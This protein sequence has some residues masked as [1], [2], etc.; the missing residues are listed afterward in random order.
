MPD[1]EPSHLPRTQEAVLNVIAAHG[2]IHAYDIKR[3]LRGVLQH[4]S[5][6]A[7]LSALQAKGYLTAEWSLPEAES[8]G[9]GPPRKY[10]EL[11]AAGRQLVPPQTRRGATKLARE[12]GSAQA[13]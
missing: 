7:A 1:D 2:R 9:G 12:A 5:V 11:T 10:F 6:Y 4:S 13:P 3:V 8:E